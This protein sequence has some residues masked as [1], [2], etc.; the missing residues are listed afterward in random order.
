[1]HNL[2]TEQLRNTGK[3]LLVRIVVISGENRSCDWSRDEGG[4]P[5]VANT[6]LLF[7]PSDVYKD[8]YLMLINSHVFAMCVFPILFSFKT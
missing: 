1:M 6:I 4:S 3:R 2:M 5:G 8:G 7:I